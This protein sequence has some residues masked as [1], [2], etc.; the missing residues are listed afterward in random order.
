MF[1][2]SKL[3]TRQTY[4]LTGIEGPVTIENG[5]LTFKEQE[6]IDYAPTTVQTPGGERV[7]FLFTVKQLIA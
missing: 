4:T 2:N 5:K 6:G 3:M 1:V 7:P